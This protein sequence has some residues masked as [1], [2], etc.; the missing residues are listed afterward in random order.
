MQ[1]GLHFIH[2]RVFHLKWRRELNMSTI[3]GKNIITNNSLLCKTIEVIPIKKTHFMNEISCS[4]DN[5]IEQQ[6]E[7]LFFKKSVPYRWSLVD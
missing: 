6:E 2:E 3:C 1:S 5:I 7:N 4:K